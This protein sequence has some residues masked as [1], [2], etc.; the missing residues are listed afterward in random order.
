MWKWL[1]VILGTIR[2]SARSRRDLALENLALCQQVATLKIRCP[3]PRLRDS[4]RMFWV[5]LSHIWPNWTKVL[6]I[7]RP[8]TVVRWHRQGFRYSWR[9][10]SRSHGR[11]RIDQETRQLV[12]V[13]LSNDRRRIL[14][15][16]VTEHPSA[17]WSAQQ[18]VEACG[19]D[20]CP[21]YL[22]RDRDAIYGQRFSQGQKPSGFRR[23]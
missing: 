21:K 3:R 1:K 12:L 8:E 20:D 7:V 16:N 15:V 2:S 4:D 17:T 10:K 11:P 9:W 13:I 6:H 18:L 19:V 14:H 23:S 22:L 5:I